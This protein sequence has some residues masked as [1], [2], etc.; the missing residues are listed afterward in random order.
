MEAHVLSLNDFNMP[1]VFNASDSAYVH[2]IQ[3]ILLEPGKYQSHPNMGVG[4]RSKYRYNDRESFI[5]DLQSDITNQITTYLPELTG[6]SV[7]LTHNDHVLGIIIDTSTG[8]YVVAYN[9]ITDTMDAAAT[10]VLEN[11]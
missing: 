9:S 1:K 7:S 6:V 3:L 8:T 10:Y 4:I 5:I 2:I 11:L